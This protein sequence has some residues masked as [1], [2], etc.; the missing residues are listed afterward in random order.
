MYYR[1]RD[2][3]KSRHQPIFDDVREPVGIRQRH[4]RRQPDVQI[5]EYVI[6]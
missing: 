5:E 6:G 2:L 1:V 3:G 4:V